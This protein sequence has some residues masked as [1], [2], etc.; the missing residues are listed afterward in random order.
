MLTFFHEQENYAAEDALVGIHILMVMMAKLWTPTSPVSLFPPPLW[1]SRLCSA[2]SNICG[3]FVDVKFSS[4]KE[5]DPGMAT[6]FLFIN[7]NKIELKILFLMYG[8]VDVY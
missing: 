3:M 5:Q 1:N 4:K 8:Y 7:C 6:L 2:I